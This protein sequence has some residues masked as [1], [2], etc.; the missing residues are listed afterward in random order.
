M[1]TGDEGPGFDPDELAR[2]RVL[3]G[4]GLQGTGIM[5]AVEYTSEWRTVCLHGGS[6][7]LCPQ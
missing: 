2:V 6:A 5:S 3:I 7:E 1:D 4:Q